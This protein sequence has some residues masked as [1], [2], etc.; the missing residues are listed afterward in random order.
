MQIYLEKK[1]TLFYPKFSDTYVLTIFTT[2]F[3]C[4]RN[5]SELPRPIPRNSLESDRSTVQFGQFVREDF[6]KIMLYGN[7][8]MQ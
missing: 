6:R 3:V 1:V 5:Q 8:V 2:A 7:A 4:W